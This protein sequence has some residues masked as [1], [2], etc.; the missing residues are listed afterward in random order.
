MRTRIYYV[1]RLICL[2]YSC[3]KI[4]PRVVTE[5][6][7]GQ[8]RALSDRDNMSQSGCDFIGSNYPELNSS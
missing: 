8:R 4:L 6:L 3:Y 2:A 7:S 1:F 5:G